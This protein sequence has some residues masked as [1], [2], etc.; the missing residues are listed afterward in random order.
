V[1][2]L[3]FQHNMKASSLYT[4]DQVRDRDWV[5]KMGHT[6]TLMDYSRFN[7]VAQPEDGIDL[8]DLVPKIGPYDK[9]ATMWG[10]EPIPGARTPDEE[11]TTLDEWARAQDATSYLR[12]TTAGGGTSD[13]GN[14][15]EAV[16]DANAVEATRLGVK[17]LERV[18]AML[19][20]A[21]TEEGEPW[22]D[23]TEL[24][25]RILGQWATEMNHVTALVGG[26]HSQQ[27]HGGQPGVR[28]EPVP[29]DAQA[30][31]V[32]FLN[33]QALHAPSFL[34][35][36]EL[37]RRMEPAGVMA[38]VKA[39]QKR[40]IASLMNAARFD[41][42]VEQAAIDGAAYTPVAFLGDLRTGVWSELASRRFTIDAFRRNTQRAYLEVMGDTLNGRTPAG[43]DLRAFVRGE[44]QT[45]DARIGAV[46]SSAGDAETRMHLADARDQIAKMLDPKFAPAQPATAAGGAGGDALD[47]LDTFDPETGEWSLGC[48]R[49]PMMDLLMSLAA[50]RR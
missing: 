24:H 37:L 38:R 4:L 46:A 29:R 48:W 23:L 11:K 5:K 7:Y 1:Y 2:T 47:T 26:F 30:G 25:T 12:F 41:R 10:Y 22:N 33:E 39:S 32:T 3:G 8:V 16:G 21:T 44:L 45:L 27:K 36:P 28:F 13:P 35:R 34:L 18:T 15:T 50:I 49:D 19:L 6:P 31:A 40:V 20:G 43:D 42:L 9:W 14:L 17:N